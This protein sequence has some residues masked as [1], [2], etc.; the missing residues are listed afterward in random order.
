MVLD[1]YAEILAAHL[2][3]SRVARIHFKSALARLIRSDVKE[4]GVHGQQIVVRYA[5]AL[6]NSVRDLTETYVQRILKP[7]MLGVTAKS[8]V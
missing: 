4:Q 3:S 5:T 8:A 1:S 7:L 6:V 2:A